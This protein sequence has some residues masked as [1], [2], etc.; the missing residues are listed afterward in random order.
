MFLAFE[1][2]HKKSIT[3][4]VLPLMFTE[5]MTSIMLLYLD[6]SFFYVLNFVSVK[7]IWLSTFFISVPLHEKLTQEKSDE[8]IHKLVRSNW[9]RTILWSFRV[10][11]I[12]IYQRSL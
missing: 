1:A 12:L 2:F 3:I 6:Q 4:I 11:I 9:I 8:T 10:L 5:L 7:L